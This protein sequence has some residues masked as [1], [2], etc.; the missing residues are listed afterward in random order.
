MRFSEIV[1]RSLFDRIESMTSVYLPR[2]SGE[3][4]LSEIWVSWGV[5]PHRQLGYTEPPTRHLVTTGSAL[6]AIVL[7][8]YCESPGELH[9]GIIFWDGRNVRMA[10]D[11]EGSNEVGG[12]GVALALRTGGV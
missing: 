7:L 10:K 12:M 9:S 5:S 4:V 6:A 8:F 1:L 2:T 3:T 11:V